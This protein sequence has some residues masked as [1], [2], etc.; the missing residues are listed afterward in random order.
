MPARS[1][2]LGF[3]DE[4]QGTAHGVACEEPPPEATA[5]NVKNLR[6]LRKLVAKLGLRLGQGARYL[7]VDAPLDLA[8]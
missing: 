1:G 3:F 2:T 8:T 5:L 4:S 6:E 7:C